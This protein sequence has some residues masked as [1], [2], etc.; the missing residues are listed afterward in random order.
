MRFNTFFPGNWHLTLPWQI[1]LVSMIWLLMISSAHYLLS[2][3]RSQ[4]QLVRMGYMPVISNLAAPL[5]DQA[6]KNNG[7]V[8]FEALKFASFAEMAEA[9]RHDHIQAAFII[10]PL[11]IVLHQQGENVRI[12]YIGNRHESTWVMRRTL[13]IKSAN[14]LV[15]KT[16]A[17]PS[18]YSGHH[19]SIYRVLKANG[20]VGK[21]KVV[22]MNPPD[23]AAS[24]AA[25]VLDGYYVGEPFAA[26]TLQTNDAKLFHYVEELWPHF[27][28][29][30]LIVK[31]QFIEQ[32]PDTVKLLVEGAAQSGLWASHHPQQAARIASHYWN[33]PVELIEY[34]LTTPPQ[35]I[36]YDLFV[37]QSSEIQELADLMVELGLLADNHIGDLVDDRFAKLAKA[38]ISNPSTAWSFDIH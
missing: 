36:R 26:K 23:M 22:E 3:E 32:Y 6:S 38:H 4:R 21:V 18:R 16:I 12:V 24:L 5:L 30:L 29:N 15:G 35:R 28:C 2:T 10:A 31:K 9:L 25:G 1:G 8:R 13:D 27:V 34:A 17:V 20:L 33:Q 14:D 37:P 19:L 7:A 11:S